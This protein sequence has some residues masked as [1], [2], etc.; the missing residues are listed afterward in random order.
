[1]NTPLKD[2]QTFIDSQGRTQK[3]MGEI[4]EVGTE[5]VC[6]TLRGDWFR[7]RDRA[8]VTGAF[9]D[10]NGNPVLVSEAYKLARQR[11]N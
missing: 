1:M 5:S 8:E 2:Q 7:R 4:K 10:K 6:W 9:R 3:V 11:Y